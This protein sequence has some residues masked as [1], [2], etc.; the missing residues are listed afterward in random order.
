MASVRVLIFRLRIFRMPMIGVP[1]FRVLVVCVLV[2]CVPIF[3]VLIFRA[4]RWQHL[5]N[6]VAFSKDH[7]RLPR[8]PA[9]GRP[10]TSTASAPAAI[11][12]SSRSVASPLR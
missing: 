1:I 12:S 7:Y 5:I 4:G 6:L 10:S 9:C 11:R 8:M 2:V 3:C